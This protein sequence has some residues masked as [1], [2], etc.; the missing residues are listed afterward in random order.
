[1]GDPIKGVRNKPVI[2]PI[3]VKPAQ[4]KP[5]ANNTPVAKTPTFTNTTATT[6]RA[7]LQM[8]GNQQK[9]RIERFY[10]AGSAAASASKDAGIYRATNA[11]DKAYNQSYQSDLATYKAKVDPEAKAVSIKNGNDKV[12]PS[13]YREAVANLKAKGYKGPENLV[14]IAKNAENAY[15]QELG[16]WS[17]KPSDVRGT[18]FA[19]AVDLIN[20]EAAKPGNFNSLSGD[21]I[22]GRIA[23]GEQ[24]KYF[25]R[26]V[27]KNYMNG[28]GGQL[29]G[30]GKDN[31][32]MATPEEIAGTKKNVFEVMQRV[33]FTEADIKKARA[34][35]KAGKPASDYQLVVVEAAGTKGGKVPTWS[36]MTDAA[37]AK[38]ATGDAAFAAYNGKSDK[39]WKKVETFDYD[40]ALKGAKRAGLE[41]EAYAKTLP[42]GQQEVFMARRQVQNSYG[43]SELYT[44]NGMT[45]RSDGQNG[46]A[47]VRE[48]W[49]DN[50]PIADQKRQ[51]FIELNAD[52]RSN[53]VETVSRPNVIVDNPLRLGSEMKT[54]AKGGAIVSAAFSL[55]QVFDQAK[56]GDYA[57]AAKTLVVNTGTGAGI[58]ALS[59][60][61]ERIVG[62][63]IENRLASST[64]TL[65]ANAESSV[66]RQVAGRVGGAGIIGGVVNGGFA[67]YDQIGAFKR[68]EVT[69]SQA[70][71]TVVGESA[72]GVGAG[73]AGAAAGAAIG[74]IIP[75]AGTAVGAVVGFVGGVV[76]G[77]AADKIMRAGGV[78]KLIAKGVTFAIDKG[79]EL[80]GKAVKF[81]QAVVDQHIKAAKAIYNS[82]SSAVKSA[83]QFVGQQV[84]NLKQNVS[85]ATRAA[86]NFASN[87]KTQVTQKFNSAVTT[88][89][90]FVNNKVQ[91]A[92][93]IYN[94]ASSAVKSA[95]QFVGQKVD[96]ARKVV[97]NAT[98]TAV[99]FVSQVKDR[100]VQT[101]NR[102]ANVV[103]STVNNAVS[104]AKRTV[105]N[106][107]SNVGNAISGGLKSVFGW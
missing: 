37:K 67:A 74:S 90:T 13:D 24:P 76:V 91:Q 58:G 39:F 96:Q 98:Q 105:S 60:G 51:A 85:N 30:G 7:S 53:R 2:Q 104:S 107:V 71:G 8:Y 49:T 73:L 78:D 82:A 25:V 89:R 80:G 9:D 83:R 27:D 21:A 86:V 64:S 100:A 4:K 19:K 56:Q 10:G 20:S 57:G 12:K 16:K 22:K 23:K 54:G 17:V 75:I 15:N 97:S 40:K 34:E 5:V 92:K 38:A 99:R 61:A 68:G 29:S 36:T 47:G 62:R 31:V 63:S 103:R 28:S 94:S 45:K 77:Y 33:G 102:A 3:I 52:A 84:T 87:V 70:I 11:A 26:I 18:S 44:G 81:G 88:A 79:M 41:P 1:M 50:S 106:A 48:F 72:V 69:G 14:Q 101:V 59:S 46:S 42:K 43:A 55:P 65:F 66:A 6:K 95:R 35:V 32:W 93:A